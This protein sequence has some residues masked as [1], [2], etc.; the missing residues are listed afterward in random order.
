MA[1]LILYRSNR[2]EKL[3]EALAGTLRAA[4]ASPFVPDIVVVQSQGMRRWL[5][6]ELARQLG[7][8]AHCR[9]PFPKQFVDETLAA[10]IPERKPSP[11][12]DRAALEWR[13]MKLLPRLSN[14][15]EFAAVSHYLRGQS[16]DLKLVQISGKIAHLFDQYL[17][18]RPDMV[19][20]WEAGDEPG[21]WQAILWRALVRDSDGAH[22]AALGHE[23][24]RRLHAAVDSKAAL[25]ARAAVFGIS[26]LPPFYVHLF[27]ALSRHMEIHLF[28]LDPSCELWAHIVS[29]AEEDRERRK[30]RRADLTSADLHAE[31][32]NS[33][34]ASLG[35]TGRDF[36]NLIL[37]LNP[38][39]APDDFF[40]PPEEFTQS[41]LLN[42]LQADIFHLRDADPRRAV[43]P[44]DV[45]L[46]IHSCHN[47]MREMEVLH[48][49]LLALFERFPDLM[50][51]DIAV[52]APD[53]Q[54]YAPY[55][56][57]VF[58]SPE[59]D[60]LR[61]PFS[62]ADRNFRSESGIADTFLK[63]LELSQSRFGSATVLSILETPSVQERFQLSES[64]VELIRSWLEKTGVRWGIDAAHRARIG[65]PAFQE[66]TWSSGLRRLLLG[67]ALPGEDKHVFKGILPVDNIEG[68]Y[69]TTLGKFLEFTGPLFGMA[70]EFEA[71]RSVPAWHDLFTR[72]LDQFFPA[73]DLHA[74]ELRDV[75][76]SLAAL[77][78]A[79]ADA[80]FDSELSLTAILHLLKQTFNERDSGSGFINGKVTFCSL[81]PMRSVPFRV[82]CLVGMSDGA[83]PRPQRVLGFDKMAAAPRLGDRSGRDDDRYLF[84]EALLSARDVFYL[85]YV[86]QSVRDNSLLPPSVLVS[87][88]LDYLE[89]GFEASG[90]QRIEERLVTRHRL[91]AFSAQY[92][93]GERLFSY[94]AENCAASHT[95]REDRKAPEVF[96]SSKLSEPDAS[97]RNVSLDELGRFFRNPCEFLLNKRLGL[98]LRRAASLLEERERFE[99]DGLT[100]HRTRELIAQSLIDRASDSAL[101]LL[102]ASGQLPPGLIGECHSRIIAKNVE[103][104]V[105]EVFKH[106]EHKAQAD[107]QVEKT[108]GAWNITGRIPGVFGGFLLS[109]RCAEIKPNDLVQSWLR[110]LAAQLVAPRRTVIIGLDK[111]SGTRCVLFDPVPAAEDQLASLLDLYWQG[112][113]APLKFF[114]KSA[115]AFASGMRRLAT[116]E[117][118]NPKQLAMREWEGNDFSPAEAEDPHFKICFSNDP[119]PLDSEFE[120]IAGRVFEPLFKAEV[121]S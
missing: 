69:A 79:A 45:S 3:A 106:A 118:V 26:S 44:D 107:L 4:P 87:E 41:T 27:E 35:K 23:L 8:C 93:Q 81:R 77:Q 19:L 78:K 63:I 2:M 20:R 39:S 88:L 55:V 76:I 42:T 29:D 61:I 108:L 111:K 94:S 57:A 102:K 83:Y 60:R 74:T 25:P 21:D 82:I 92:F 66:N 18:F 40:A 121:E 16:P 15:P 112:L 85:S 96:I 12:F 31:C 67:Y 59:N 84:L 22:Q 97:F 54:A 90:V 114:P 109:H 72:I 62:I 115:H 117:D 30:L 32:R 5:S 52:M 1:G 68:S 116:S 99:L 14:R 110:H 73:N 37:D 47:P 51:K 34:L 10:V 38:V 48:D 46:Q 101:T 17:A 100:A 105:A 56:D 75:R 104:F 119:D 65:L 13:V 49:Q 98:R 24:A 53:I 80:Q 58:G 71:A 50:P 113:R 120:Q 89:R 28:L 103:T 95:S 9:F 91:Q 7:V 43:A 86:G 11:A 33:L 6:L 64:E 36:Q 70:A